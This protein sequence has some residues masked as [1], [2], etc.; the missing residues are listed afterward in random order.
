MAA[1]ERV[2]PRRER[3]VEREA[4][5]QVTEQLGRLL[6]EQDRHGDGLE[7]P[8]AI[9]VERGRP[10]GRGPRRGRGAERRERASVAV[11]HRE[12]VGANARPVLARHLLHGRRVA[13]RH[14]RLEPRQV[15]HQPGPL[16]GRLDAR[17]VV[18]PDETSGLVEAARELDLRLLRHAA[19]DEHERRRERQHR[20]Q[21]GRGEDARA[22][23]RERSRRH[24]STRSS[25]ATAP[26]LDA[27]L[28]AGAHGPVVPDRERVAARG[29]GLQPIAPVGVGGREEAVREHQHVGAHVRV[30]LAEDTHDTRPVEDD[31][32]RL[33]ARV[34]AQVEA[35]RLRE[36]EDV[37]V[38]AVAVREVDRA[39]DG[40]RE[41]RRDEGLVALV[42][43]RAPGR[44]R[45]ESRLRC[46]LEIHDAATA[47][48]GL[49]RR[50]HP[51]LG[52]GGPLARGGRAR[53]ISIRPR[54]TPFATPGACAASVAPAAA[55]RPSVKSADLSTKAAPGRPRGGSGA[56][57]R[58]RASCAATK[59]SAARG[60]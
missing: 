57:G 40:D 31:R 20:H 23:R 18:L 29:H 25:S 54:I 41:H 14:R 15:G 49:A 2:E 19:R 59:P 11:R 28:A 10:G 42:E 35:A 8:A 36:R 9:D 26:G 24:S 51:E 17:A 21:R 48:G 3:V 30:D 37:V 52:H 43:H 39:A 22:K 60:A 12:H 7:Q 45:L 56:R 46:R 5:R 58:R 34:A 53:R 13:G 4:Q 33:A 16:G 50:R 1:R 47:V 32:A 38:D 44:R 55:A 27:Q 6:A